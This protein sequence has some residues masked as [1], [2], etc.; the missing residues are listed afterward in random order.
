[1]FVVRLADAVATGLV[2]VGS[3][4]HS[5]ALLDRADASQV[6]REL[7]RSAG[8]I[9]EHLD[10]P[11]R[12]FAYPKGVLGSAAAEDAVPGSRPQALGGTRVNCYERPTSTGW[13]AR[14][15]VSDGQWFFKR[16]PAG[17]MGLEGTARQ[18]VN[19]WRYAGHTT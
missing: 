10:Q 12:H 19:R 18:L 13:R 1:M 9:Q 11:A 8:L 16:K 17:G 3:H 5:H 6:D 15:Q 7:D 4:T 2:S 14:R